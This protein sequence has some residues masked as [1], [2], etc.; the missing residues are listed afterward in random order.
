MAIFTHAT[1]GTNDLAAARKLYDAALSPLGYKR[2]FDVDDRSGYG[3]EA[4]EF[5]VLRPFDGKTATGGNGTTISFVAPCRSAVNEF[6]KQILAHG[7][8]C[9][10]PPGLRAAAPNLYAAYVRD[11][12]GNKLA[13]LCMKAE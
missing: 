6:H 8:K 13:A 11:P 3:A 1:V 12:A 4:P 7:G 5:I 10:G 2:L 9:E